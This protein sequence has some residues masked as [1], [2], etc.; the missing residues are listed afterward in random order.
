MDALY[1]QLGDEYD[2]V[3]HPLLEAQV[4]NPLAMEATMRGPA[5]GEGRVV[6]LFT[7]TVNDSL[8]G[9][10]GYVSACNFYPRGTFAASNEAA[11]LYGR[12]PSVHESPADW[13]RAMRSTVVHEAKHLASFAERLVHGRDVEAPWLEEATARVAEELYARTFTPGA[14]W[15][16]NTGF[17]ASVQCE[18][19]MCDDRPL[20]MWK[21]FSGLYAWLQTAGTARVGLVHGD[22]G[23]VLSSTEANAG[24]ASGWAL[25]RWVLD[26]SMRNE[27]DLL[28]SLVAGGTAVGMP[29]LAALAGMSE[30]DLLAQWAVRIGADA[31]RRTTARVVTADS[32]A[33]GD[34]IG[35]MAML[36][37]GV[38]SA[39]PLPAV[40]RSAGR[41]ALAEASV[42]GTAHYLTLAGNYSAGGQ[43]LHLAWGNGEGVAPSLA[44]HRAR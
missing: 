40:H 21:H 2:R 28:R 7:R 16:S 23:V 19:T 37:P 32:W 43:L 8:P 10:A 34:I 26:R 36:F 27:R 4:G 15:R 1:A 29:A 3:M 22:A 24:Y 6:L 9:T 18:V 12:V 30:A 31:G 42:T 20:V 25:V 39:Q 13:R 41:F 35:G 33:Y 44:V 11:V 38:F 5:G 14:A 17:A